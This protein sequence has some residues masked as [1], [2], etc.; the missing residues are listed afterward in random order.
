MK[1]AEITYRRTCDCATFLGT[2]LND[3]CRFL[4]VSASANVQR[5]CTRRF[6]NLYYE[7]LASELKRHGLE[8]GYDRET[9]R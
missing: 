5:M 6:L 2:G 7:T 8:V 9:V 3:V 4:T 1:L